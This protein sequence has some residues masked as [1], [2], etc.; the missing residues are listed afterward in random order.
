MPAVAKKGIALA[1]GKSDP[2]MPL[3]FWP[4]AGLAVAV[5]CA[6]AIFIV[7]MPARLKWFC[8]LEC[9]RCASCNNRRNMSGLGWAGR[10]Q[11]VININ[12]KSFKMKNKL[13]T[14]HE[15]SIKQDKFFVNKLNYVNSISIQIDLTMNFIHITMLK[16]KSA[17]NI[18]GTE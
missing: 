18:I 8:N 12:I 17:Y 6:A 14:T 3:P 13:Q 2:R 4:A 9:K 1:K 5:A 10:D 15:Q 16:L 11:K 7:I